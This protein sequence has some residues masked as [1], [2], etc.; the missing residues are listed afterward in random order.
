MINRRALILV[1]V[2]FLSCI[3]FLYIVWFYKSHRYLPPP[4]IYDKENTFMDFY[5]TLY[6][7]GQD[8][9]Y[10]IWNSVYPP[11]SFLLLKIYQFLFMDEISRM[12]DGFAIRKIV[13][14]NIF[15]LL[16]IY[17][18]SLLIAVRLSFRQMIDLKA[19]VIIFL[20]LL[21]SPPFLFAIERGNLLILSIPVLSWFIFSKSQ[22]SRAL[23]LAVL[24]N[25]KPYFA[26][27]YIVQ[28]FNVKSRQEDED[29]L[30]LAP[31]FALILFLVTGLLLNQ[32]FYLVPMNLFGFAT[33]S[34]VLS[35]REV[36]SFP[37]SITAF[38][39]FRGLVTE[40]SIPP[41]IGYL[42]K[43]LIYM[44]LI[45]SLILIS[46]YKV[47][48]EYLAIFSI[49]FITNYSISTGGYGV[50][51]YIPALALMY[52]QRDFILLSITVLSMYVGLWD[53]VPIYRYGGDDMNVYLSGEI[54]KIEQYI[55]LG[56][57][58]KPMANFAVL[59]L[60][61]NLLK[62]KLIDE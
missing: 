4:F 56:S 51:Y 62:K 32:E 58:I 36:L 57:V 20:I 12:D 43:V 24:V 7:S 60:F 2:F 23:A 1:G 47:K 30:F 31:V 53:M 28:L 14:I 45:R 13:G 61:F 46:K 49:I 15:P 5:N 50:L 48:F 9:I 33:N 55:G 59:V 3:N 18:I 37:S 29:F 11:L 39:Y 27:F 21:L 54:V 38:A 25:L 8:G 44:Y 26:V 10:S 6:W 52:K 35:P 40:Y 17:V 41:I 22:I 42:S 16:S 34:A 19:Q